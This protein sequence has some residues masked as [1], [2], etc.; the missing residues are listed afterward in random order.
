MLKKLGQMLKVNFY[1]SF[2]FNFSM[3]LIKIEDG[4]LDGEVM[5]HKFIQKSEAEVAEMRKVREKQKREKE[6]RRREQDK[7]VRRKEEEK[8]R[9]KE[10]SL[11]GMGKEVPQFTGAR[12]DTSFFL[13]SNCLFFGS[14]ATL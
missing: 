11:L 7:N 1:G 3:E 14:D 5:Y 2:Y 4:L 6:A 10:K 13:Y 12:I 8:R 9:N